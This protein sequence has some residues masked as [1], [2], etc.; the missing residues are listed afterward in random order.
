[1]RLALLA[2]LLLPACAPKARLQDQVQRLEARV[3]ALEGELAKVLSVVDVPGD[4]EREAEAVEIAI[5]ARAAMDS[6]NMELARDLVEQLVRDYGDTQMGQAAVGV[7]ERLE[8]IGSEAGDL[9]VER[10]IRG[11][12][13][14]D[15]ARTTLVVF[16]E[17]WCPHCQREGPALQARFEALRADGLD[18]VALTGMSR[19]TTDAQIAAFIDEAGI[20]FPVGHEDGSMSLRYRIEG[21]PSAIL[22]RQGR[23]AWSG[24][25]AEMTVEVL[26]GFLPAAPR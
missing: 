1:M 18:V 24:H 11:D 9:V 6:L 21:V 7:A 3:A 2:A 25:P 12:G 10:W 4:P 13:R 22:I 26:R 8:I 17:A 23:V 16:F 5:R 19:G 15:P 14:L 20:T